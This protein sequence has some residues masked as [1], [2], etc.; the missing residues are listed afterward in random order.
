MGIFFNKIDSKKANKY[1]T[2]LYSCFTI[3]II[4]NVINSWFLDWLWL[5]ITTS[6]VLVILVIFLLKT[7]KRDLDEEWKQLEIEKDETFENKV[8]LLI[9]NGRRDV[10]VI[11]YI[12][13]EKNLGLLPAKQYFDRIKASSE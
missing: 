3:L 1:Q 9:R 6:S 11:K 5:Y 7:P 12:R 13:K 8:N 2:R 4:V 10:D